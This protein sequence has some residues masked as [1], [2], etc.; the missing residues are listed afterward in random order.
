[1]H[2]L[3]LTIMWAGVANL[4]ILVYMW[5]QTVITYYLHA[6]IMWVLA[7]FT[8]VGSFFELVAESGEIV[9]EDL[10]ETTGIIAFA[11]TL[12]ICVL[13]VWLRFSQESAIIPGWVVHYSR[14]V[15]V[16]G[17]IIV[18]V[19]A[20]IALLSAWQGVDNTIFTGILI[21]QIVLTTIRQPVAS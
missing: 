16:F 17:G 8:F 19:I 6:I 1:M 11:L 5:R 21:W 20:Q 4:G 9:N 12:V 2:L 15:H 18:W 3:I 10:H 7:I 13:G 14:Y